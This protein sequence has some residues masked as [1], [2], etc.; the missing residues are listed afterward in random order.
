MKNVYT[1][2][3]IAILALGV[4]CSD[5]FTT[6]N[7]VGSLSDA[8][9]ANATGVD[10][11]LT[12]AYSV[13]DGVRNGGNGNGWG[14]S[15]DNWVMDVI[16]DDAHKG[17][18][19]GDQADL[20]ELEVYNWQ[21]GNGY[22]LARWEVLYAGVNRANA[23]ISL[24][25]NSDS[26]SDF[27]VELA[28]AYF[29]RGH[30]NF[31]LKKIYENVPFISQENYDAQEFS[32]P[33]SGATA[34]SWAVIESDFSYAK[35]NLPASRGGNYVEAGRPL[36]ATAQAFLGK[37]QLYQSKWSDALGNLDAVISSGKFSLAADFMSN[38]TSSGENGSEAM[39]AIQYSADNAQS[40]QG[41][42]TGAL[43]HPGGG[44]FGSCCGFYQPTQDLLDAYQTSS[45]LPVAISSRVVVTSDYGVASAD[46]FTPYAGTLDPRADF[47]VGRRGIDYN[48]YGPHIGKDW[49]RASFDDISG[50]YLPKK[51]TFQKT[52]TDNQ[53]SGGWGEQL[54]G[55]N[56]HIMR[57]A[58][59]L[60]MAA[61]AAVESG[62]EEK[63]RGYVNKVR[64]RALNSTTIKATDGSDAANYDIG[65]YN[66]S[67]AGAQSAARTAVRTERRLEFG[68]EGHR[69]F[70]LRRW[71]VAETVMNNYITR[72]SQTITS[73]AKG[74]AYQGKH[75]MFP[76]PLSAIDGSGG[77]ISQNSGF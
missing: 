66:S 46:A 5:D 31:E 16:S 49:I 13:L 17:S 57:Y 12:G 77:V 6:V 21:T 48:G 3:T 32:Q 63:A 64:Q 39:F 58:D 10:L 1:L 44:P 65:L 67:W 43:N 42:A 69:S 72:E 62:D 76:I 34:V 11:L 19:D 7:P 15:A 22:F 60:L 47:T 74:Q 59:V 14:R 18:T 33:N 54:T 23:V 9:L 20:Y 24:I 70:D 25:N 53:G 8:A 2:L 41:N 30:F 29:L 27:S 71:G 52:D 56:Y 55:I 45:G 28:Q 68:M 35:D 26:P 51:N 36:A 50:P 38:W 37:A 4:S 40:K 75:N 61:E 73:F